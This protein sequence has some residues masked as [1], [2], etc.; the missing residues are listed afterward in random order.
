MFKIATV[1]VGY[2]GLVAASCFAECGNI[3]HCVD[4]NKE[5]IENLKKGVVPIYEPGLEDMVMRNTKEE[6]MFFHNSLE[7]TIDDVLMIFIAVGTPSKPDGSCDLSQVKSVAKQIGSLINDY[8]I[9]INKSTSPIGTCELIKNIIQEE[10]DNRQ[11]NIKFDVIS[12]QEFLKEGDALNDF[13]RPDR[14]V[15]GCDNPQAVELMKVLYQPFNMYQDR[16]IVVDPRSAEMIK[17]ASNCML[18]TKIS[19]MNEIANICEILGADV[20]MVRRGMGLDHRI[21]PYFIYP[22]AGY[23]GSCF[24]KDI[25]A[26]IDLSRKNNYSPILLESVEEVNEKQKLKLAQMVLNY[27][28]DIKGKTLAVWG[29][30]FK[31]N[32]DDI[33]CKMREHTCARMTHK[34]WQILPKLSL[35]FSFVKILMKLLKMLMG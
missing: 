35:I 25:K 32:T 30:S 21:G 20:E 1:G 34:P 11:E 4:S 29:L 10:L 7:E 16:V 9:I 6:R 19:F 15:L 22:G 14:I 17:Y 31:P 26:L 33:C 8:K 12:N 23:G 2:V 18:S 28:G 3:V 13:L 5:R 27:F 24:P